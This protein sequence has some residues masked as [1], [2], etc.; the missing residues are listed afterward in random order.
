MDFIFDILI[1]KGDFDKVN[2]IE[3]FGEWGGEKF[4]RVPPKYLYQSKLEFHENSSSHYQK[5]LPEVDMENYVPLALEF[6]YLSELEFIVNRKAYNI[7]KNEV[8]MFLTDLCN[9]LD[10]FFVFLFREEECIDEVH[11]VK[12]AKELVNI[13]CKSLSW[14]SP[15]GIIC[16]KD[17]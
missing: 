7:S 12:N 5:A 1:L 8:V 4:S 3:Q 11:R 6:E 15:K 17:N 10:K 13:F 14:E 9:N 16:I 2:I